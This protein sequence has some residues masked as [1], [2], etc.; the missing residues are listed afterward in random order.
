MVIIKKI[1]GITLLT[2]YLIFVTTSE[3]FLKIT[4]LIAHFYDH[5]TENT[6]INLV[7][8]LISHYLIEDNSDND[9][10]EDN[11]LPFKSPEH[12]AEFTFVSI[13]PPTQFEVLIPYTDCSNTFHIQNDLF[14]FS[15]YLNAI[16]QPPRNC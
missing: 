4:Q 16:W 8:F 10:A 2:T 14:Q 11:Q 15:Q 3:E 9:S 13:I 12:F 6:D 5:K 1:S 7:S